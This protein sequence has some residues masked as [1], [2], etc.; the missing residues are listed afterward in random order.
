VI[1]KTLPQAMAYSVAPFPLLRE[2]IFVAAVWL[3]LIRPGVGW[4]VRLLCVALMLEGLLFLRAAGVYWARPVVWAQWWGVLHFV[5][6]CGLLFG[7][8]WRTGR[9]AA[10]ANAGA[11]TS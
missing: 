5:A 1:T 8:G 11:D 2:L 9:R 3:V 6:G 7:Y 4:R 10:R